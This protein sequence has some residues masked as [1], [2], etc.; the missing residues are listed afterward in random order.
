MAHTPQSLVLCPLPEKKKVFFFYSISVIS[1]YGHEALLATPEIGPETLKWPKFSVVKAFF[2]LF[3]GPFLSAV[4]P[5]PFHG[6]LRAFWVVRKRSRPQHRWA[7]TAPSSPHS[8]CR[9]DVLRLFSFSV[10]LQ[11]LKNYLPHS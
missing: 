10:Y 6:A 11:F 7:T 2:H 8:G 1:I 5:N 9:T 3:F 4:Q